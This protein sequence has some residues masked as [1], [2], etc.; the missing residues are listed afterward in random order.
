MSLS[1]LSLDWVSVTWI[2]IA[3]AVLYLAREPAQA[4]IHSLFHLPIALLRLLGHAAA[5]WAQACAG[6]HRALLIHLHAEELETYIESRRRRA[7]SGLRACLLGYPMLHHRLSRTLDQIEHSQGDALPVSVNPPM[8]LPAEAGMGGHPVPVATAPPAALPPP[9]LRAPVRRLRMTA[10]TRIARRLTA[11]H[12]DVA[13]L[14]D[15]D[16][17]IETASR[18]VTGGVSEYR[19]LL[20]GEPRREASSGRSALTLVLV[21]LL[22]ALAAFAGVA[23]N[24]RLIARPLS[25]IVG[26]GFQVFGYPL[27]DVLALGIILV[28]MVVGAMFMDFIGVTRL[29]PVADRLDDRLRRLLAIATGTII[30][31]FALIEASLAL[32]REDIVQLERQLSVDAGTVAPPTDTATTLGWLPQ[33]VQASLGFVMPWMLALVAIPL[34]QL[35]KYGRVALQAVGAALFGGLAAIT[36]VL[37]G[38]LGG[39]RMVVLRL[40]DLVIFLPLFVEQRVNRTGTAR[41]ERRFP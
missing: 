9:L 29:F 33:V 4:L 40:Y 10:L 25:E 8:Q 12:S 17:R 21:G 13:A 15:M 26:E 3:M 35:L 27:S 39:M 11:I 5:R 19:S 6:R 22:V 38:L 37:A 28:E 2:A 20:T 41:R 14:R 1:D 34:E 30:L 23:L 36:R 24:F 32:I 18:D 16:K 7:E 31:A